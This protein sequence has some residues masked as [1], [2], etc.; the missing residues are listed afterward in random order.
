MRQWSLKSKSTSLIPRVDNFRFDDGGLMTQKHVA[1]L[2][3]P[4]TSVSGQPQLHAFHSVSDCTQHRVSEVHIIDFILPRFHSKS[5]AGA[6]WF[7]C[8]RDV[9]DGC[10]TTAVAATGPMQSL[11]SS[12]GG[13]G[14]QQHLISLLAKDG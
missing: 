1:R 13:V 3:M 7:P 2:Q 5:H 11:V 9:N 14:E 4:R 8:R 6:A 12:R 10:G